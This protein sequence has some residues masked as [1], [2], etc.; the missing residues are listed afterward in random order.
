MD[1]KGRW[2]D[3]EDFGILSYFGRFSE[4]EAVLIGGFVAE[5]AVRKITIAGYKF[6]FPSYHP[7]H[8]YKDSKF[9]AIEDAYEAGWIT[10]DDVGAIWSQLSGGWVF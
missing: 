8:I 6:L 4:C 7:L 10:A 9:L 3:L 2:I 5:D 1:E